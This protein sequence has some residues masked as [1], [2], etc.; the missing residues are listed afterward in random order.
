[1]KNDKDEEIDRDYWILLEFKS[2]SSKQVCTESLVM[3]VVANGSDK[4]EES[5]LVSTCQT[6]KFS[7]KQTCQ[8]N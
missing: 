6:R 5:F 4:V 7:G 2:G 1:M 8:P 3:K